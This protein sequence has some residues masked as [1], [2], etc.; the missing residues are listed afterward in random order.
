M[1]FE[2]NGSEVYVTTGGKDHQERNPWMVFLHGAGG[3][4]LAWS[5]QTRSFAYNGYNVVAPDFPGHNLSAGDPLKSVEAQADWLAAVMDHLS[6]KS[7]ILVG[8][9]QGGL[10]CLDLSTKRPELI[11]K[12]VFVATAAAIPVNNMLTSTAEEHEPKAKEAMTSWGL[13]P[14]AHQFDNTVPG[15]SHIGVGLR[16]MD[17]NAEGA[18]P[19]DLHACDDYAGGIEVAKAIKTPTMCVMAGKDRM[20]PLKFG[21]QLSEALPNNTLHVIEKSGHM[22]PLE[23]PRELNDYIREF[24]NTKY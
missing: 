13:G 21:K 3:S 4:H 8:H 17:L 23:Y 1:R 19:A 20:T 7:A 12:I 22:L 24:L 18:L 5:Q 9:S 6:I 16:V 10:V 15:F 11:E 2:I 14:E